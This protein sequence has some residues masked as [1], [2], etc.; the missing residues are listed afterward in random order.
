MH[1]APDDPWTVEELGRRI[2]LS[3]S[4]LHERFF[5]MVGQTPMQ[6]LASWRMQVGAAMVLR[7]FRPRTQESYLRVPRVRLRVRADDRGGKRTVLIDG[8]TFIARLLQHVLPPG[9][10]RIRLDQRRVPRP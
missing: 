9:F 2:G 10:N 1:D 7:G 8:P 4:A 3:R 6:Y 5:E